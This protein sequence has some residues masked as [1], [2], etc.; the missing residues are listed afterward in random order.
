MSQLDNDQ[1]LDTRCLK[2]QLFKQRVKEFMTNLERGE[3]EGNKRRT[4]DNK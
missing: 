4:T 2:R 3:Y 1:A